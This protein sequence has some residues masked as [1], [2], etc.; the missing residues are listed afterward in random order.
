MNQAF[1]QKLICA[2][3]VKMAEREFAA[4]FTAVKQ[5]FGAEQAERSAEDWLREVAAVDVLPASGREWRLITIK[6]S[7]QLASRVNACSASLA[8]AISA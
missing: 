6:A 2:D 7:R 8:L 4:F 1:I 5:T 3:L